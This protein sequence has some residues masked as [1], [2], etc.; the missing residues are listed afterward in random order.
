MTLTEEE[1]MYLYCHTI[2]YIGLL[3]R[4]QIVLSGAPCREP[5][6]DGWVFVASR[7]QKII[8]VRVQNGVG[9]CCS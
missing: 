2:E 3:S 9:R 7:R 4:A 1:D 8:M 6:P 5:V